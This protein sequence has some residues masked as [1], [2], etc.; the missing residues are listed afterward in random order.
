MPDSVDAGDAERDHVVGSAD[1][2]GREAVCALGLEEDHGIVVADRG[3]E[4]SLPIRG[5]RRDDDLQ[6]GDVAVRGLHALR[7]VHA[8][9]H[10]TA[11][12]RPED[13][14]HAEAT[15]A[16][17]ADRR[18]LV[19][20]LVVR[21]MHVVREL[22]LGDGTQ[23]HHRGA[24][25][26]ARD[27][28]LGHR[29]VEDTQG[30]EA[31]EQPLRRAEHASLHS[32]VLTEEDHV[33]IALHLL[34][35]RSAY[36]FDQ[37][38]LSH[39]R[40]ASVGP[41]RPSGSGCANASSA[42][43]STSASIVLRATSSSSTSSAPSSI[44][45]ARSRGIGSRLAA[46]AFS[47]GVAVR[48]VV[49]RGVGDD[50]RH[51]HVDERRPLACPGAVDR[52]DGRGAHRFCVASVDR[53]PREAIGRSALLERG[54][55]HLLRQ[56]DADRVAVVL[57]EEDDRQLV[58]AGEVHRLVGRALGRGTVTEVAHRDGVLTLHNRRICGA[59]C[60][61]QV[62]ADLTRDG[63]DAEALAREMRRE[64]P[65]A[66]VGVIGSR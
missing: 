39:R 7:V 58:H 9:L 1:R 12:W 14:G 66:A 19:D 59:D 38:E 52:G 54:D 29:R 45:R 3:L 31:L 21:G 22:E 11:E 23:P 18:G 65:A 33:R 47:L 48:V 13:G 25:R 32:D 49:L 50:P 44:R 40:R 2:L 30:A 26:C 24:Y 35:K 55:G 5:S 15:D 53:R 36:R 16:A 43:V 17:P 28:D 6:A 41:D 27:R 57:A 4:Q 51:S 37:A 10:A 20:D 63:T 42:A 61:R 56:R 8:A 64:L 62:R 46:A 60:V 34:V